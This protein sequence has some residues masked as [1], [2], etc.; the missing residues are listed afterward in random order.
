MNEVSRYFLFL[1]YLTIFYLDVDKD[2]AYY[3][4][5]LNQKIDLSVLPRSMNIDNSVSSPVGTATNLTIYQ[6]KYYRQFLDQSYEKM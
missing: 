6:V 2:S 4:Q 5:S 1:I 3:T